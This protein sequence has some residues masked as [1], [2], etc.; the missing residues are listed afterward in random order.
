MAR[1]SRC[2]RSISGFGF[3]RKLCPWCQQADAAARGEGVDV[4]RVETAPWKRPTQDGRMVTQIILGLNVAVF[5]GMLLGGAGLMGAD[6]LTAVHWGANF[7]PMTLSGQW[8][9]LVTSCFVHFGLLHIGFNMWC[10]WSLGELAERLYGRVTFAVLYL[11][12]G[13]GGSL[14]SLAWHSSPVVSAGA[15]GAIFGIA[16]AIIASLKLGNT[17]NR[18]M[19]NS[20][21]RS[22]VVFVVFNVVIGAA[23][24]IT[25]NACHIG[26]LLTGLVVGA[27]IAKLAPTEDFGPRLAVLGVVV[28]LL[29]GWGFQLQH[30]SPHVW[31]MQGALSHRRV[32]QVDSP[33]METP[34]T[35]AALTVQR[36]R[37]T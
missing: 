5:V 12:C 34:P 20:I 32:Q 31:R 9:R 37:T 28:V 1:C 36:N 22:L 18:W 21:L 3:G 14:G 24:G 23:S 25:D 26:G 33:Q 4:Q 29:V 35:G 27:L 30:A 17:T 2:G 16:G 10:L 6:S 19:A 15:S 8:W 13:I 7:A 11:L